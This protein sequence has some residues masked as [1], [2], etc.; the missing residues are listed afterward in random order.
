V[1]LFMAL[2]ERGVPLFRTPR[3]QPYPITDGCGGQLKTAIEGARRRSGLTE[4][5]IAPYTARHT[6]GTQLVVA[7]V[8]PYKKG[9]IMGH[10]AEDMSRH[11]VRVPQ[12][13]LIEAINKLPVLEAWVGVAWMKD[14]I[15]FARKL[16]VVERRLNQS[17]STP[18]QN[19][20][21]AKLESS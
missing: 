6:V 14:P 7:G 18:V 9:Q 5:G 2:V 19:P 13:P 21:S 8:H 16:A 3:N 20:C 4:A 10:V 1:P 12:P 17:D 11:Y 15:A